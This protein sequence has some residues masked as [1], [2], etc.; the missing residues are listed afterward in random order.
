MDVKL[1][2]YDLI[3]Q[4]V[5]ELIEKVKV[6]VLNGF[7]GNYKGATDVPNSQV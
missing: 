2:G 5:A 3:Q 4:W 7:L 1:L 6:A